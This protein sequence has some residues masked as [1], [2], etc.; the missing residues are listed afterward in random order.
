M[1][2]LTD[3]E[4]QSYEEEKVC[5]ICKKEFCFD[6]NYQKVRDNCHYTGKVRGAAHSI[7][8]LNYKVPK[9]IPIV[10]HNAV[11]DTHFIIKQLAEDFDDGEF[12]CKGE[13]KEK[14][15]TFSV[16]IEKR[17]DNG[18]KIIYK[19]KFID[20]FRFMPTS[21]SCLVD[22]LSEINKIECKTCTDGEN[23]K[24]GCEFIRHKNNEPCYKY[25]ECEKISMKLSLSSLVDD[26]SEISKKE[27]KACMERKN[28]KSECEFI[29]LKN[30]K[31]S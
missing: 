1:I 19:L 15:I 29:G 22:N 21:S 31:L 23:I 27:C 6:K 26:L 3:E 24:S 11:Y 12:D 2:L 18:E 4:T 7:C 5:D 25:K 30:N 14:Y 9:E 20:S 10:I 17:L 28:I 8:N 16:P 13:N